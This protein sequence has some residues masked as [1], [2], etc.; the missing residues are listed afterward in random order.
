LLLQAS[1]HQRGLPTIWVAEGLLTY[2]AP[3][4]ARYLV[5]QT[6]QLSACNSVLLV[7][8]PQYAGG[9]LSPH[10]RFTCDNAKTWL[11]RSQWSAVAAVQP[12]AQETRL[13][14]RFQGASHAIGLFRATKCK[15]V[16]IVG[17]GYFGTKLLQRLHA[18]GQYQLLATTTTA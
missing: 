17:C 5:Q 12:E 11:E 1:G 16:A 2:L 8:I 15:H 4:Q 13:Y 10:I 9:G 18:T 7:D 14:Q 6:Y 3:D